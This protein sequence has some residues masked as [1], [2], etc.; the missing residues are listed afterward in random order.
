MWRFFMPGGMQHSTITRMALDLLMPYFKLPKQEYQALI[1]QYCRYPDD[2]FTTDEI[3]YKSILPYMFIKDGIQF[4]YLPDTPLNDLYRYWLPK[5]EDSRLEKSRP[6][7]NNNFFH[8]KEG[9]EFYL[10]NIVKSFREEKYKEGAKFAGCLMHMLEDSSFGAH[11]LEG[12]YGTDLFVLERLFEEQ[13]DLGKAPLCILTSLDCSQIKPV[14]YNPQLLGAS[15]P[16]IVMRLYAAYV[17]TVAAS[18]RICFKIVQNVYLGKEGKNPALIQEMFANTAKTC[19]DMLFSACSVANKE[20]KDSVNLK[21]ISLTELEPF[22]FPLG[23]SG[24][25]RFLSY[26][27]DIAV[28]SKLE[29]I[30]LRLKLET[31]IISF[32]NGL[33]LGSHFDVSLCYWIPES[34][35]TVF[36]ACIGLHPDSLNRTSG[37]KIQLINDGTTVQEF[38]FNEE[39][40]SARIKLNHPSGNFGFKISYI[41][42]NLHQSNIIIIANPI[43]QK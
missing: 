26:L 1:E 11:S 42:N 21:E 43:L 28:N 27:K 32:S 35:Y 34:V 13:D 22:E 23:S 20:L 39:N 15:V 16:E 36:T 31:E 3:L 5:P 25:Y 19:A 37:V 33:S 24:G 40:P 2:F 14:E 30:P 6:F 9:F 18:R 7:H 38:D 4:H 41:S 29:K 17:K 10:N 8:A 12:P